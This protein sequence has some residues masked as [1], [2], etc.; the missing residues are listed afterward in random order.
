MIGERIVV[1]TAATVIYDPTSGS[2]AYPGA[3]TIKLPSGAAQSVF[4]GGP[5]VT[6]AAGFELA[7]GE[8]ISVDAVNE[9]VYGIVAATTETVHVLA[10]GE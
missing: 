8:S 1:T 9:K 6:A 3:C 5:T 10:R 7:A 2:T 4:L